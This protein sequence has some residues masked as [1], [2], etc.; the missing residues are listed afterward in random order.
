MDRVR[1]C[2][3]DGSFDAPAG[4]WKSQKAISIK[5]GWEI[6]T[7]TPGSQFS[8]EGKETKTGPALVFPFN[9]IFQN[10]IA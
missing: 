7:A 3:F 2:A 5:A 6:V 1:R 9:Q 10:I 8:K 4:A